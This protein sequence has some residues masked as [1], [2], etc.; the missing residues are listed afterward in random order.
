QYGVT[1]TELYKRGVGFSQRY[2]QLIFT[3]YQGKELIA[4]QARNFNKGRTKYFTSGEKNNAPR[5]YTHLD[6]GGDLAADR[7]GPRR[8]VVVE[9]CI[10]AIK[11]ARQRD[12]MPCL[13]C[14]ITPGLIA[15]LRGSY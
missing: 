15:S 8:L 11:I 14:T 3:F 13:G 4:W 5:T 12:S 2:N 6:V 7:D 9:D 10:S 1:P